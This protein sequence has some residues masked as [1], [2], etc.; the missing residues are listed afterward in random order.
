VNA[1]DR[2]T[3][4]R[5]R[6]V[7]S[8]LL[9]GLLALVGRTGWY[10]LVRGDE[11]ARRAA[12]QH[13][14]TLD[15]PAP[16]GRILDREGRLLA[17]AYHSKT[18][19][20]DPAEIAD[21]D[22]FASRVCLALGRPDDAREIAA[23]LR[24]KRAERKRFV[25]V[26][27]R[28]E[29]ELA[30]RVAQL[31]LEG[32]VLLEEPRRF[33]PHGPAAG[34]LLGLLD[35]EGR[36]LAGLE[37]RFDALL[38]G[39]PGRQDVLRHGRLDEAHIHLFPESAVAPV[40]GRD[41]RL[42][43]DLRVQQVVEEALED[44]DARFRPS[45]CCA[46]ALDPST[47]DILAIAG[48]PSFDAE[49][50]RES[51]DLA[52]L[53]VHAIQYTYEPG[54]TLKPVILAGALSRGAVRPGQV[55]DCGDGHYRFGNRV[56]HDVHSNGPLDL[57]QVL[58]KS[59]NI[60]M[61][62]VG[63]A[64]GIRPANDLLRGFGFG[65]PTGLPVAG[66]SGGW[67]TPLARWHPDYTLVSVSMGHEI[68][69]SPIQMATALSALAAGG[70]YRAP[71]LLLDEPL[72]PERDLGLSPSAIDFT[73]SA[74]VKVVEE[75]TG[76]PAAIPGLRVGG[77]TGTSERLNDAPGSYDASFFGFAPADA[78]RLAVLVVACRP[79]RPDGGVPYG[80]VVASPAV[81]RILRRALPL[82]GVPLPETDS[83]APPESGVRQ[84]ENPGMVRVAAVQKSG[85]TAGEW[86][87]PA[88]GRNP[89]SAGAEC[90][91]EAR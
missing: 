86:L 66:E 8:I 12:A 17:G 7:F 15:I 11:F 78:P 72:R 62:Q 25:Y 36:G 73:R 54:S 4:H 14:R 5:V 18:V 81:G 87:S 19:V 59:S 49:S 61:A 32:L 40:P 50:S 67:L 3:A 60:G 57:G 89:D 22:I 35:V 48:R 63:R 69:V 41:L 46:V 77:K 2:K 45:M 84:V 13:F 85:K 53:K 28:I 68:Q 10:Q 75:G 90:R 76:K 16:R 37:L 42:T 65:A 64:L 38:T 20:A 91:R 29:R 33:Y 34:A 80:S 24:E 74:M 39:T 26:E 30:D 70:R 79:K 82:L 31:D 44:L 21:P 23:L 83:P 71:R 27:R 51:L 6:M 88:Q 1:A 56:L 52:R 43:I 55:F 9:L 58:V 47:G